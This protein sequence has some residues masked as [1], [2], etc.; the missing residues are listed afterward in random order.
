MFEVIWPLIWTVGKKCSRRLYTLLHYVCVYPRPNQILV[1]SVEDR[2]APSS[3]WD[4]KLKHW[5]FI[6]VK[7][8]ESLDVKWQECKR[9]V[10]NKIEWSLCNARVTLSEFSLESKSGALQTWDCPAPDAPPLTTPPRVCSHQ[11]WEVS[12]LNC[13]IV[14]LYRCK[15]SSWFR[16]T[17]FSTLDF[18]N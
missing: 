18:Y 16:R 8:P 1:R 6:G 13:C 7:M 14:L 15:V 4:S 2:R 5:P 17:I 12:Q 3:S 10:S 9:N 11:P